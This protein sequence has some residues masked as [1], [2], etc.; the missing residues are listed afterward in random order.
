MVEQ[1]RQAILEE[2]HSLLKLNID[3]V[4]LRVD[5]WDCIEDTAQSLELVH[6]IRY[7]LPNL[8]I[9]LTCR[10]HWEGGFQKVSEN[11]KDELYDNVIASKLVDFVDKELCYGQNNLR[12]LGESARKQGIFLIISYHDFQRTPNKEALL[13]LFTAE[14]A[15]GADVAKLAMTPRKPEDVI[16]LMQANLATRRAFPNTP[17]IAIS[18]GE[19]GVTS[20]VSGCLF[21]SDLTFAAGKKTSAPGQISVKK[22]RES[23]SAILPD[24]ETS[25]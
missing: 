13:H 2:A 23:I 25:Q 21:G 3:M 7:I 6:D 16:A 12:K 5:S 22:L 1:K 20:R 14:I 9:I 8:P 10:G 24:F 15:C 11:A 4:E 18:M 17:L 19:L